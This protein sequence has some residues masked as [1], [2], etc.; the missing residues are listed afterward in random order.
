MA[1]TKKLEYKIDAGI[2]DDLHKIKDQLKESKTYSWQ[3][4][5]VAG[6]ALL[7]EKDGIVDCFVP[8]L[9]NKGCWDAPEIGHTQFYKAFERMINKDRRVV[10][11]SIIK[12]DKYDE[13]MVNDIKRNIWS[14]RKTFADITQTIWLVVSDGNII[15]YRPYKDSGGRINIRKSSAKIWEN[16][17]ESAVMKIAEGAEI[18]KKVYNYEDRKKITVMMERVSKN[19]R[20]GSSKKVIQKNV[21]LLSKEIEK[22]KAPILKRVAQQKKQRKEAKENASA[23]IE[24]GKIIREKRKEYITPIGDGYILVKTSDGREMLWQET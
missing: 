8:M 23:R 18:V 22:Q 3:S 11:M 20:G 14:W 21:E 4:R 2:C 15:P 7:G 10:G 13:R 19:L 17:D 12:P 24:A 9:S 5:K 16:K 1:K 6:L